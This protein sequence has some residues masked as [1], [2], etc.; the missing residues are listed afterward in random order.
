MMAVFFWVVVP[1][2]LEWVYQ[3]FRGMYCL[4]HQVDGALMMEAMQT[5]QTLVNSYQT[6]R[7]YNPEDSHLHSHLRENLC[8][9]SLVRAVDIHLYSWRAGFSSPSG[10]LISWYVFV[11]FVSPSRRMV[12]CLK[13][14]TRFCIICADEKLSKVF[15]TVSSRE[16]S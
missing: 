4:H 8:T 6:T 2:K 14:A 1:C 15:Y 11:I 9:P 13:E 16:V 7:R 10:N 12:G 3:R 5:S